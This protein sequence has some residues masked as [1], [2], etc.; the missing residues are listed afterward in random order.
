MTNRICD[1]H[2]VNHRLDPHET[3]LRLIVEVEE[4]T[5]P[6]QI[7]G[8]LMGPRSLYSS[9]VE[10]AYSLK[11]IERT[12]RIVLRAII[13][14]PSLWEPK[15]P[16]LYQGPLE[17]WQ[18]GALCDRRELS[19]GI[20]NLQLTAKGPRLNGLPFVLRGK[21]VEPPFD[22]RQARQWHD[23]GINSIVMPCDP[24]EIAPAL[25]ALADRFG[26]FLMNAAAFASLAQPK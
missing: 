22:E 7:R 15:T 9:T 25:S 17:L 23:D 24:P 16:F 19:H 4:L 5:P 14:E 3:E 1:V 10:I 12:N 13:P 18:D 20:R 6:T 21:A 8:R 11:E 2:V 26:F